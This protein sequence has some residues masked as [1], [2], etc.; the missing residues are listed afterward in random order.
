M[1]SGARYARLFH[2]RPTE[3]TTYAAYSV[4]CVDLAHEYVK[5]GKSKRASA[6]FNKCTN[7]LKA[8]EVPDEVRLLYLLGHAEVLALGDNVPA[9][10]VDWLHWKRSS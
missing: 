6:L 7:V 4:I 9:R 2:T 8:G 10:C 3:L 1:H 5:L